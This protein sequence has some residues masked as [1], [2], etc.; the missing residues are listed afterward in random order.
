MLETPQQIINGFPR[1]NQFLYGKFNSNFSLRVVYFGKNN[2]RS[3]L[4]LKDKFN[5]VQ[6]K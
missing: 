6:L 2:F 1:W 4:K 3:R 5:G